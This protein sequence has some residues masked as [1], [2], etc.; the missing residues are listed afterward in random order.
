M[1]QGVL[2]FFFL[3]KHMMDLIVLYKLLFFFFFEKS[4]GIESETLQLNIQSLKPQLS[5]VEASS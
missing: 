3:K 2:I 1:K 5:L 4:A